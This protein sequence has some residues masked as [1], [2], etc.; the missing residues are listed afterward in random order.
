M[1]FLL[2][3]SGQRKKTRIT[4]FVK[5]KFKKLDD[6]TY[7]DKLFHVKIYVKVSK[8]SMFKMDI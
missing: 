2:N 6:Q 5:T 3:N 7:I 1:L 4:T 8:L